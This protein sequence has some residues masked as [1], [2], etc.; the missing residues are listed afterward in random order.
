MRLAIV[1]SDPLSDLLTFI[2]TCTAKTE[3][4]RVDEETVFRS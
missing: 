1:S 3:D 4:D 2:L